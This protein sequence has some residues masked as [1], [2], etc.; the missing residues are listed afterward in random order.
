MYRFVAVVLVLGLSTPLAR[1]SRQTEAEAKRTVRAGQIVTFTIDL[2][3]APSFSGGRVAVRI[4]PRNRV[5][6]VLTRVASADAN[7]GET[8]LSI[9]A[10][11]PIGGPV[12]VWRVENVTFILPDG[13]ARPL[14]YGEIEF[15]VLPRR[16]LIVPDSATVRIQ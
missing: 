11:I 13:E 3:K 1:P 9:S 2:D 12:G 5:A 8:E 4:G 6:E 14:K 15:T 10:A 7:E 16:D